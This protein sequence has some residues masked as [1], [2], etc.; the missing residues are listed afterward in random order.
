MGGSILL[1]NSFEKL[2]KAGLSQ[3][4]IERFLRKSSSNLNRWK[5]QFPKHENLMVSLLHEV[6]V[7]L[8]EIPEEEHERVVKLIERSTILSIFR[9]GLKAELGK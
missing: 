8:E 1:M 7:L 9:A 6:V 5:T 2:M 3:A 4:A